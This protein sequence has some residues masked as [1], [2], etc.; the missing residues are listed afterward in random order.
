MGDMG[1]VC[2]RLMNQKA[3][4]VTRGKEVGKG[5]ARTRTLKLHTKDAAPP[6]DDGEDAPLLKMMFGRVVFGK[7]GSKSVIDAWTVDDD[8]PAAVSSSVSESGS[9]ATSAASSAAKSKRDDFMDKCQGVLDRWTQF[10]LKLQE[11]QGLQ[12]LSHCTQP[13]SLYD[14]LAEFTTPKAIQIMTNQKLEEPARQTGHELQCH[15][16]QARHEMQI[17]TYAADFFKECNETGEP[18]SVFNFVPK[19]TLHLATTM[20]E[21]GL[22]VNVDAYIESGVKRFIC[23]CLVDEDDTNVTYAL[24]TQGDAHEL[25]FSVRSLTNLPRGPG[26]RSVLFSVVGDLLTNAGGANKLR[27]LVVLLQSA[28]EDFIEDATVR[29][30]FA[31]ELNVSDVLNGYLKMLL[32]RPLTFSSYQNVDVTFCKY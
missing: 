9:A 22:M 2:D 1:P 18:L 17:A 20:I 25:K 7:C 15:C 8:K 16:G 11:P 13:Q 27:R 6:G 4:K 26:Q 24:E 23:G 21:Q 14:E 3:V 12:T 28:K 5:A 30:L 29:A 31:V 19:S 32:R 10:S